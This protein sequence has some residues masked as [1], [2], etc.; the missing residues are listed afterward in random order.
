MVMAKLA[1]FQG[2]PRWTRQKAA[3]IGN[4]VWLLSRS[5]LSGRF[6]TAFRFSSWPGLTRPST[7]GRLE[8]SP[9]AATTIPLGGLFTGISTSRK[10]G[11]PG[12]AG[13]ARH[14]EKWG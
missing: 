12:Q 2:C 6:A 3:A 13:Q 5:L 11:W 10:R 4:R 1:V 8:D 14:D 7:E 9:A